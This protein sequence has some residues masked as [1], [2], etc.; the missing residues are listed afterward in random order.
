MKTDFSDNNIKISQFFGINPSMFAM[1]IMVI[2][3]GMGERIAERYLPLYLITLG[4]SVYIVGYFNALQNLLGALY[5]FPSGYLS[6]AW[7]YKRSL[8]FFTIIAMIGYA[9]VIL[10]PS[11]QAVLAASILFIAWSAVSLPPIMSLV[12]KVASKEKRVMGVTMHSLIRRIPMA[13]GPLLGGILIAQYGQQIGIR[14]AFGIAFIF[15]AVAI[16]IQI[17]WIEDKYEKTQEIGILESFNYI[18]PDLRHLLIS[19]ILIRFAEQIPNAFVVLWVVNYHN[20]P[21]AKFG[22]LTTIEMITAVLI[23][24]PIAYMADKYGKKR[25]VLITFIFFTLFP[26]VLIFCNNFYLFILAF[27]IRGLKEFGEPTRKALIMDLAPEHAKAVTFG[28]YYLIRDVI[29]SF[30]AL[31][32]APLWEISPET[33][34]AIAGICGI[35]GTIF[36][37][38]FGRDIIIKK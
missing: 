21:E 15:A 19:D 9:I 11:W 35:I 23:Y 5:S 24:I 36:F 20:V 17:V 33:N 29:V 28:T 3:V 1:L 22:I 32:S 10:I 30:A 34:F 16:W 37:A 26:L 2:F 31:A 8:I 38:I 18:T 25:F 27:I 7:G 14:L 6:Q 12:N 4:G 13:I